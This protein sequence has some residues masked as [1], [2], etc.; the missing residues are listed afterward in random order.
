MQEYT[1]TENTGLPVV[2]DL[3]RRTDPEEAVSESV[4]SHYVDGPPRSR[5][6][7]DD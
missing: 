2:P 6:A 4:W 1:D 5:R 7:S 3:T